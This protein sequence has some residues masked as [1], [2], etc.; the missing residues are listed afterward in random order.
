MKNESRK[1]HYVPQSLLQGFASDDSE[2]SVQ[3]FDKVR[4]TV[5]RVAI[6]N[7]GAENYFNTLIVDGVKRNLEHRFR[8]VDG[9]LAVL[10]K[11]LRHSH[12]LASLNAGD[13][14]DLAYLAALQ[15]L[16]VKQQRTSLTETTRLLR[17]S[18]ESKGLEV[19]ADVLPPIDENTAK[20]MN[21]RTLAKADEFAAAFLDKN[22][23]LHTTPPATPFWLSDCPI[24]TNNMFV[25]GDCGLKSP[26]VEIAWP[27]ASDLL[28]SFLCPTIAAKFE[29][30]NPAHAVLLRCEPTVN[31]TMNAVTFYNSLQVFQSSRFLYGPSDDFELARRALREHPDAKHVLTKMVPSGM[32]VMPSRKGM[33]SGKWLVIFGKRAHYMLRLES[34]H[35]A[36]NRIYAKVAAESLAELARAIADPPQESVEV[37]DDEAGGQGMQ[38]VMIIPDPA[39]SSRIMIRHADDGLDQLGRRPG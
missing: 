22:W 11:I 2:E 39:D 23:L 32:G 34:W 4:D 28:L 37:S 13:R 36:D 7:A 15:F 27:L 8:D 18:L 5:Q 16:R 33:P 17:E 10:L 1:H 31:A 3:V 24:V 25:Y 38:Y 30:G 29:Q 9:R 14:Q 26:G 6:A 12:S 20:A 19:S 21:L 35:S